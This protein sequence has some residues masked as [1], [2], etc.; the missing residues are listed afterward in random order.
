MAPFLVIVIQEARLIRHATRSAKTDFF[1]TYGSMAADI[2]LVG[3]PPP[4]S[5]HFCQVVSTQT[6][7]PLDPPSVR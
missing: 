6:R 3:D 7:A 2:L 4:R 5:E 1:I